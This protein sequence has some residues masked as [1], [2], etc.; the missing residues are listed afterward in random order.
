MKKSAWTLVGVPLVS[1]PI[2]FILIP[3]ALGA[4]IWQILSSAWLLFWFNKKD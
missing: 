2:I 1:L 3:T 4:L